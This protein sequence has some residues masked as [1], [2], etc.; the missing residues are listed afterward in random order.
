MS[1]NID[2]FR[3]IA[4]QTRFGSRDIAVQGQGE[5]ATARLGN[6]VFSQSAK[7]NDATMAAFRQALQNEYGVFGLHAFDTVVGTRAQLHKSLRACDI[8]LIHSQMESL[9]QIRFTNELDRQLDTNPE[10]LKL[11]KEM[12]TAIRD[13]IHNDRVR[14]R[15][16]M[17]DAQLSAC[18]V[19]VNNE[20]IPPTTFNTR[21]VNNGE[22]LV[23][24]VRAVHTKG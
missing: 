19:F 5:N 8:K 12:R 21:K 24:S 22:Q 23:L 20:E 15:S 10:I 6:F 13:V 14:A 17:S 1:L 2:S 3:N 11:G 4:S 16:G 18:T 9:K 7:T